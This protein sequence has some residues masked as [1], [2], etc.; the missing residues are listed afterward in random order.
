M[1]AKTS[2]RR[3]R[4]AG[5]AA[6]AGRAAKRLAAIDRAFNAAAVSPQ[7]ALTATREAPRQRR[8][9][10][11]A[12]VPDDDDGDGDSAGDE[13]EEMMEAVEIAEQPG[14]AAGGFLPEEPFE[15]GGF[16]PVDGSTGGGFCLPEGG[17]ATRSA[18]GG[19][20]PPSPPADSAGG[21]GGGF[22]P[23]PN[24]PG[25]FFPED[26]G[27]VG[28][29]FLPV[30]DSITA[31]EAN[32]MQ[33]DLDFAS[34][35]GFLPLPEVPAGL[36]PDVGAT[37]A[38]EQDD[39]LL[40]LPDP[41]AASS[42]PP[43]QPD[44]IALTAIPAALRSLGLHRVGLQGAEL[45]ALFEEVASDDDEAEGGKSVQRD[46]FREACQVLL[47]SDD[48]DQDEQ[49]GEDEYRQEPGAASEDQDLQ[50]SGRRRLRR[51]GA[52]QPEEPTR[53]QPTRRSTRAHPVRQDEEAE[54]EGVD[55][56]ATDR[57]AALEALPDDFEDEEDDSSFASGSDRDGEVRGGRSG[58]KK[59]TP[60][61]KRGKRGR[62]PVVDPSQP[63]SASEIAAASDTFDLFFE[64][65]PQ[66]P[67]PQKDRLISLLE[68]QRACRVLKEKMTD[69]ELNEMLEYAARSQGS[70]NLE[71]FA[72]ILLET[73]L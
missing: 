55:P 71:A 13:D 2:R 41:D 65:S 32:E 44:R 67:F 54:N 28:G 73:G 9:R 68:L 56:I 40:P 26:Q 36:L 48:E 5:G 7:S 49:E 51:G 4:E 58:S 37:A 25:G 14:D 16:I 69:G 43:S 45:M 61:Q 42:L 6:E 52:L 30:P 39:S 23:D 33:Q 34:A 53:V 11:A 19:F 22:L 8:R 3:P 57:A 15:G 70:V 1:P 21:G 72:R 27:G 46:R 20:L 31:A 63:L 35:G 66:L 17:T 38:A 50:G 64:E 18:E 12:V 62:R 29:G 47:G 10:A 60:K 59:T 24:E